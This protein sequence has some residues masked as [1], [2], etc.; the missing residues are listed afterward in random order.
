M[1]NNLNFLI[2]GYY[3]KKN[4]GDEAMLEIIID[5]LKKIYP[6]CKI[7]ITSNNLPNLKGR[8]NIFS[9][10]E[11]CFNHRI[12]LRTEWKIFQKIAKMD[13]IIYGGGTFLQDYGVKWTNMFVRLIR[14]LMAKILKKRIIAIG[15]GASNIETFL[16]KLFC[17]WIVKLT[18]ITVLRDID[19]MNLLLKLGVPKTKMALSVDLT[20]LRNDFINYKKRSELA[21]KNPIKI[22]VSILPFYNAILKNQKKSERFI[23]ELSANFD[24]I[25][26]KF[27]AKL[28]FISMKG[29]TEKNDYKFGKLLIN[30]MSNSK[31]VVLFKYRDKPKETLNL[32]QK[33]DFAIGMRLHFVI[34]CF[35][36]N[37]PCIAISYNSKVKSFMKSIKMAQW[38]INEPLS[39]K[40]N[41]LYN[42]FNKMTQSK[43]L[44][45]ARNNR[46]K[47]FH[48]I[49]EK[50]FILLE[51][52]IKN[53][54]NV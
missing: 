47:E 48:A 29:G 53:D 3:G 21:T 22:G 34:F 50:N 14:T 52:L 16:G 19:S 1:K 27:N 46:I 24:L 2:H 23:K 18:D 33:M 35:L 39:I 10:K 42:L 12:T 8:R 44:Y 37:I 36:A 49:A 43:V 41:A 15:A 6:D 28:Y 38:C 5:K 13:I 9:A 25:L 26:N 40:N 17:R 7:W 51:E 31:K 30:E 54:K 20:F 4:T 11:F 45:P 32:V